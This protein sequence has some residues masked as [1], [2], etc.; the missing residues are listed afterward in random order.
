M[1]SRSKIRASLLLAALGA[2]VPA[3]AAEAVTIYEVPG[4]SS[5]VYTPATRYD[6]PAT[7][8]YDYV[9]ETRTYY[10]IP[11]TTEVYTEAPIVVYGDGVTSDQAITDDVGSAIASDPRISGNIGVDTFNSEVTLTGRVTTPVQR[12]WADQDAK[13][14][15]GVNNVDNQLR[16]R[17]GES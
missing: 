15:G 4:T 9:P 1:N 16:T 6:D 3:L 7:T 5:D 10:S 14:V 12:D 11:A 8:Q 17:V 13:G 2:A